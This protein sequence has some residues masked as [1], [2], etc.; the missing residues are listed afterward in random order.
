MNAEHSIWRRLTLIPF[1]LMCFMLHAQVAENTG[2]NGER[3]GAHKGEKPKIIRF[4]NSESPDLSFMIIT[5]L[6]ECKVHINTN[7][8]D[9]FKIRFIN[10]WGKTVKIYRNL[11]SGQQ[12][13]V[14]EFK[15]QIVIMNIMD[16]RSNHLL[17]SQVVNL[18]RRNYWRDGG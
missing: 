16:N 14:S 1:A 7:Y 2:I 10:Y 18:K 13:D 9:K 12:I 5:N 17:S 6:K 3:S 15:N 8:P 11:E 4:S